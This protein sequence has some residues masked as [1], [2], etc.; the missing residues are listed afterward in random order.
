M[1]GELII[2]GQTAAQ[3][4]A[5]LFE[6]EDCGECGQG[7]VGHIAGPDSLGHWPGV[8]PADVSDLR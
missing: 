6:Y 8:S 5:A 7:A 4:L 1:P 3:F 2:D